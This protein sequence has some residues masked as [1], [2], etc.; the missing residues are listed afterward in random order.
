MGRK[1]TA[2]L[3]AVLAAALGGCGT[4]ANCVGWNGPPA[5]AVY[6]GVKQ[7]AQNGAGHLAEAFHGPVP[8][9][10]AYPEQPAAGRQLMARSVCAACGA[11]MLAVDLPVSLVTDTLTLPVTVPASLAK[12]KDNSKRKPAPRRSAP[13]SALTR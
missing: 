12:D 3:A 4:V 8:S 9:F 6:G 1:A 5:R 7:D 11:C 2:C 13:P 10:S